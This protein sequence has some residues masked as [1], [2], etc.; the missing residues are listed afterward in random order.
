MRIIMNMNIYITKDNE[1]YLDSLPDGQSKSGLINTLL[2]H[3]RD[4]V[5]KTSVSI[6]SKLLKETPGKVFNIGKD[7]AI[8]GKKTNG[9]CLNGHISS[10]G[11]G[12]C[13]W[14][15]CKYRR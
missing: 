4:N 12:Q 8:V 13:D 5:G 6:D 15:G 7:N 9:Y 14:K 3:H 2:D 10:S 1:E 11:N